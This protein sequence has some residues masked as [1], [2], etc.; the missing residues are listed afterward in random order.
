[1]NKEQKGVNDFFE[2]GEGNWCKEISALHKSGSR[3]GREV[4]WGFQE[5]LMVEMNG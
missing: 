4:D 2:V 3:M 5:K 1:M